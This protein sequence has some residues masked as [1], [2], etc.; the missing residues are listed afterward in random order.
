[1]N[2]ED[3]CQSTKIKKYPELWSSDDVCVFLDHLKLSEFKDNF[4]A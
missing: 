2:F 3:F 1:M 4:K